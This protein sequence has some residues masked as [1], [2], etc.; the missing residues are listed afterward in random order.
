M[1]VQFLAGAAA[2]IGLLFIA[3]GLTIVT[4]V[5]DEHNIK[6]SDRAHCFPKLEGQVLVSV[7][8][9]PF[10]TCDSNCTLA[11]NVQD[12]CYCHLQVS[13][14][15]TEQVTFNASE[16]GLIPEA[17][18]I[19]YSRPRTDPIQ[20]LFLRVGNDTQLKTI[21]FNSDEVFTSWYC[22]SD[23]CIKVV[24][25]KLQ[26][27]FLKRRS[28]SKHPFLG[29]WDIDEKEQCSHDVSIQGVLFFGGTLTLV[30]VIQNEYSFNSADVARCFPVFEG[31]VLVAVDTAPWYTCDWNRTLEDTE[32]DIDLCQLHVLVNGLEEVSFNATD[33]GL[34]AQA[35]I[36]K[37]RRMRADPI[38]EL[39]VR[40]GNET[41]TKEIT[42]DRD[43]LFSTVVCEEK[44][45]VNDDDRCM[46]VVVQK[47][48]EKG[49]KKRS[50]AKIDFLGL[51]QID[52]LQ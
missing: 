46:K 36:I 41:F 34:S 30:A 38:K 22:S 5:Q 40:M 44:M 15:G 29:Q 4:L 21:S 42:F 39:T 52:D 43:N 31:Q 23:D 45:Q 16:K 50:C 27:R 51:W 13:L 48:Y 26:E 14:D 25:Q 10:F 9:A 19:N 32:K 18:L 6:E 17:M 28:C 35:Q 8:A 1:A 7:N 33:I 37:F 20:N 2:L 3:G 12:D 49:L 11:D 47:L 24:L